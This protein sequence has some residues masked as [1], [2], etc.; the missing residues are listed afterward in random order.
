[1]LQDPETYADP[2]VFKPERF[3][4]GPH[5]PEMD[6]RK[7]VFGFGRRYAGCSLDVTETDVSACRICPGAWH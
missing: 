5:G 3:L 4:P 2:T 7:V 6:P 1:M